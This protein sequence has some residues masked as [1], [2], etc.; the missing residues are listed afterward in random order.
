MIKSIFYEQDQDLI[1][2]ELKD[3]ISEK[4][5]SFLSNY[6][7]DSIQVG[8]LYEFLAIGAMDT[9]GESEEGEEK[10]TG[11]INIYVDG[12]EQIYEEDDFDYF[13]SGTDEDGKRLEIKLS[14]TR[15]WTS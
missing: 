5:M 2:E 9:S 13:I 6:L 7:V 11:D 3:E 8:E 4:H 14:E 1:R 10:I 12:I 15:F